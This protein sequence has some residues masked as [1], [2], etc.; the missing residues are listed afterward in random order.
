MYVRVK[1]LNDGRWTTEDFKNL[2]IIMMHDLEGSYV[3]ETE[4]DM[5]Q[6]YMGRLNRY[7]KEKD[8]EYT[9]STL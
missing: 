7:R 2:V 6:K 3:S 4:F 8:I 5:L 9:I 1:V